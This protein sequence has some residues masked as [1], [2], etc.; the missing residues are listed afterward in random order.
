MESIVGD[1]TNY[2]VVGMLRDQPL[3]NSL[4]NIF[5]ASEGIPWVM[6]LWFLRNLIIVVLLSP[7]IFLLMRYINRW[8]LLALL[9]L[10]TNVSIIPFGSI[11]LFTAGRVIFLELINNQTRKY[12][13]SIILLFLIS[14]TLMYILDS[15]TLPY[16]SNMISTIS[17]VFGASTMWVL[18][19]LITPRTFR[20]KDHKFIGI[21]TGFSF[22][23]YLYHVPTIHIMRKIMVLILGTSSISYAI[24]FIFAP[25]IFII[26]FSVLGLILKR[27]IPNV[28]GV[29][30]GGR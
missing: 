29:L 19:D 6:H 9:L 22:F 27:Y 13:M 12:Q 30:V 26:L 7:I 21:L 20:L 3:T 4:Y 11:F 15:D 16:L 8:L 28:Y 24:V 1:T 23:V 25:Y 17:V 5:F 14:T 10:L 18:Y 2:H